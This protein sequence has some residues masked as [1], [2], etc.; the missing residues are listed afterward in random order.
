MSVEASI[1]VNHR[2]CKS[3]TS[4]AWQGRGD[5]ARDATRRTRRIETAWRNH[6]PPRLFARVNVGASRM[7]PESHTAPRLQPRP[8]LRYRGP[9][10]LRTAASHALSLGRAVGSSSA[11]FDITSYQTSTSRWTVVPAE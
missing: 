7:A 1:T 3:L 2:Q 10:R 9:C 11:K 6:A 5:E 4:R 8:G